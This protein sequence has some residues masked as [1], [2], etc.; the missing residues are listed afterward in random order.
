ML[1]GAI[2]RLPRLLLPWLVLNALA[3]LLLI[4]IMF[5]LAICL[6]MEY[7]YYYRYYGNFF[8]GLWHG[9]ESILITAVVLAFL[10]A[11]VISEY[12]P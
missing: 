5:M 10:V 9:M 1:C 11:L 6:L 12:L 2:W 3:S 4:G 7:V 8:G